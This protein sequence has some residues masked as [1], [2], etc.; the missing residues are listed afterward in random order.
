VTAD[1]F[2][3]LAIPDVNGSLRGKALRPE[4]FDAAVRDGTVMTDLI[5]GLDPV[6]APISDFEEFG[7]RTGAADLLV[8]P[9]PDTVHDLAWRPGWRVCLATPRWPDGTPCAFAPREVLR[10]VLEDVSSLGFEVLSAIE[11][12]I[13]IWDEQDEPLSSGISYSLAEIGRYERFL[14]GLLAGTAALGVEVT[15]VHTEAGPGLLELNIAPQ[16]GLRAGDD[17]ALLKFAVK[18]VA[19]TM[20][21]RASF[22]AKTMP[23]E[24]GSSGHV[25]LSAWREGTNAFAGAEP[26]GALP[27]PFAAAIAGVLEHL[28]AAS[29]LLNPTINSYKRLVPG[30]FAPINATWGYENRSCAVRAIRSERPE[31]W[32]FECR[33]P[34]ADANPYLALAAIAASAADGIRNKSEPPAPIEGDAYALEDR[35]E[36]PGSLES[37]LA[38]FDKDDVLRTALGDT[39]STYY[40]TTRAWELKAWRETVTDW[41]RERYGRS[42]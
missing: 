42:V 12:E 16:R 33:R 21:L 7:I 10:T 15:A 29:L 5:L 11:Y 9:D 13:R 22:L 3:L 36:L 31:L 28:P 38:A 24:E 27:R 18:Q 34:G 41:E 35:P 19:A 2:V 37:A 39:F 32:R 20:G 1:G 23:G 25:H 8:E 40:R 6:D 17:A 14:D 30:W 26:A 4:A